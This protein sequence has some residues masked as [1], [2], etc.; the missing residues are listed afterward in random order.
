MYFGS[1]D[2]WVFEAE[3]G[4]SFDGQ[5]IAAFGRLPLNHMG[6]PSHNKRFFK[7][8][9]EVDVESRLTLGISAIFDDSRAPEQRESEQELYGGGG[10]WDEAFWDEVFWD[11]PLNG[12][13]EFD[14]IGGG[15]NVSVLFRSESR[16][17]GSHTLNG[18]SIHWTKRGLRKSVRTL[19]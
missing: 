7:A 13:G 16:L 19:S 17:E 11:S 3:R 14:L 10:L 6:L 8:D 9:L 12:F 18:I 2:G 1:D 4:R 5:P 15:R